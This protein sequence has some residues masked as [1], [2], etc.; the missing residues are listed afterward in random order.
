MLPW[1]SFF[2]NVS[3]VTPDFKTGMFH[4]NA[5]ESISNVIPADHQ[6]KVFH[7]YRFESGGLVHQYKFVPAI[8]LH[9]Q[10]KYNR[11]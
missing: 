5:T 4:V 1:K 8:V 3:K 7:G 11:R 2:Q 10:W 9:S 6:I